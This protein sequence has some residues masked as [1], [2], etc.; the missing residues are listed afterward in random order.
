[1]FNAL[2]FIKQK[3]WYYQLTLSLIS[4]LSFSAV[5]LLPKTGFIK[6]I[7]ILVRYNNFR[8][9]VIIA[10]LLFL[11]FAIKNARLSNLAVAAVIFPIFAFALNGLWASMYTE[12]NVIAGILPRKDAFSFF[13]SAMSLIE[14]GYLAGY[15]TGRKPLFGGFFAF[16]LWIFG[17]NI[18]YTLASV[19]FISA[20]ATY[21]ALIEVRKNFNPIAAIIFFIPQF[22]FYRLYIGNVMSE[23]LGFVLGMAAISFFLMALRR[24]KANLPHSILLYLIGLFLFTLSQLTRP[25]AIIT[26]PLIIIFAGWLFKEDNREFW[27][28]VLISILIIGCAL[29]LNNLLLNHLM[30]QSANQFDN[31]FYGVYGVVK[32][33]KSWGQIRDDLPEIISA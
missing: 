19:A 29:L 17:E 32:G 24:K 12:T 1:M 10:I 20:A 14:N 6:T 9:L 5:F 18:Q 30:R 13:T 23:T 33:G 16:L 4:I 15:S 26:L 3:N 25:G 7:N 22:L 28:M 27:K 31:A 8:F 21:F 11:A 2:C